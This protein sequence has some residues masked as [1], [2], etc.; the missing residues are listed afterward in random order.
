MLNNLR[1]LNNLNNLNKKRFPWP[2]L[3]LLLLF[4]FPLCLASVFYLFHD[5]IPLKISPNG[6]LFNPPIPA[7]SVGFIQ[8]KEMK[9]K[10][11]LIYLCESN[12][13]G[14]GEAQKENDA[15]Y[16]LLKRIHLSLGKDQGRVILSCSTLNTSAQK[17]IA[18]VLAKHS[19]DNNSINNN[20]VLLL[21]PRGFL[22]LHYA[23]PLEKPKGVLED[24]RRLLRF[25]H[26]G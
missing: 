8:T 10:W 25:S 6:Q 21:D 22:I 15:H 19:I 11:Q 2:L 18:Q 20:Q 16:D 1:N 3:W 17:K 26:V 14:I 5:A 23:I 12:P 13:M 9:G 4:I 24:I 7:E